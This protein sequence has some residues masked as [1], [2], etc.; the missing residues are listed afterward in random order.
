MRRNRDE[1]FPSVLLRLRASA[2]LCFKRESQNNPSFDARSFGNTEAQ[3][4][5]SKQPTI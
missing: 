4:S 5:Q 3:S 1:W 2:P